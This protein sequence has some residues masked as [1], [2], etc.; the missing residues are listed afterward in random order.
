M[1]T[2]KPNGG[3]DLQVISAADLYKQ[4]FVVSENLNRFKDDKIF[5]AT[6]PNILFSILSVA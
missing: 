6:F 4:T 3:Q 5:P 1:Q 2:Y